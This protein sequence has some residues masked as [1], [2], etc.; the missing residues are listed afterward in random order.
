[1]GAI[2]DIQ[3][4]IVDDNRQMRVLMRCL[5]RAAG[6]YRVAEAE[7]AVDAFD[8]LN[9][10]PIDL[11]MVDWLMKPVDGVAFARMIRLAADSPNPYV[12]ILMMTAHTEKWRVAAARDAGVNGFLKKPISARVLFDR[13]S[14]A[15]LDTREFVR[16]ADYFGPDRRHGERA[17]YIGPRRRATDMEDTFDIDDVRERA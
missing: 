8:L 15:L 16:T 13:M 4:L 9:R 3:V 11:V 12:P 14:A 7:G 6:V 10:F 1:M 2:S 5:L 17:D